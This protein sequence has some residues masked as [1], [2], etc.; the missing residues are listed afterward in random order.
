MDLPRTGL[1]CG[2]DTE[3]PNEWENLKS[4]TLKKKIYPD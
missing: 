4:F 2:G 3:K 1:K